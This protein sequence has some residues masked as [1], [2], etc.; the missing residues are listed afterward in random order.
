VHSDSKKRARINAM[1]HFLSRMEYPGKKEEVLHYDPETVFEF[2]PS[3]YKT[4]RL[5]P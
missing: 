4:G 2:D 5:A 1:Q 3:L